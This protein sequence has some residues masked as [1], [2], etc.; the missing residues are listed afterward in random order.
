MS[1]R[2]LRTWRG[3][4]L[5]KVRAQLRV[6]VGRGQAVGGAVFLSLLFHGI[7]ATTEAGMSVSALLQIGEQII[8]HCIKPLGRARTPTTSAET[9]LHGH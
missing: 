6:E 7:C 1:S 2:A 9:G 4:R 3:A 8:I 5:Q